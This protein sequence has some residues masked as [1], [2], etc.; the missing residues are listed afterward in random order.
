ME[1]SHEN[2][3]HGDSGR[4]RRMFAEISPRYDLLNRLLS[5]GTDV[6]WRRRAVRELDLQPS[7]RIL[8]L[9][10]GTADLALEIA[11]S[12]RGGPHRVVGLDF[13]P[14]MLRIAQGKRA[15]KRVDHLHLVQGDALELPFPD[16]SFDA[17]TVAFGIRNVE[18][19]HRG[20]REMRRVLRPDGRAAI[21]EF[22]PPSRALRRRLFELY[23]RRVLPRIGGWISGGRAGREAYSYLP[24]SVGEFPPSQ[25][26]AGILEECGLGVVRQIPLTFA[27]ATLHVAAPRPA[28]LP[29]RKEPATLGGQP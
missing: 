9:C 3:A 14:E 2:R 15:R 6:L 4:I 29:A 12:R 11:A 21:L 23:F 16:A 1:K 17:V 7:S 26:L 24:R 19:L 8:D 22:S 10:T 18:D 20:F 5:C 27:V 13:T 25:E 28:S